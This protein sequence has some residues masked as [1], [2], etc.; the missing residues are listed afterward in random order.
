MDTLYAIKIIG[1]TVGI[2][3]LLTTIPLYFIDVEDEELHDKRLG[4]CRLFLK[5]G[6]CLLLAA[7]GAE[8]LLHH[9]NPASIGFTSS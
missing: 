3:L 8:L 2:G 1:L 9:P 7:G 5:V 6:L 4:L